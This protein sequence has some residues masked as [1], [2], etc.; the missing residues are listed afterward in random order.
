MVD[1]GGHV[2]LGQTGAALTAEELAEVFQGLAHLALDVALG[3]QVSAHPGHDRPR[4]PHDLNGDRCRVPRLIQPEEELG[5]GALAVLDP[6]EG[7]SGVEIDDLE[8]RDAFAE[9][10][11]EPRA[12]LE[13][14]GALHGGTSGQPLP[15]A[16][17]IG[18]QR[19]DLLARRGDAVDVRVGDR[20]HGAPRPWW[21]C[22]RV[23]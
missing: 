18:E 9:V 12:S 13:G 19:V 8:L 20:A 3:E 6:S 15:D 16:M 4:F 14:T 17:R 11:R 21:R 1:R 5:A 23:G 7:V 22:G 2:Q 10:R